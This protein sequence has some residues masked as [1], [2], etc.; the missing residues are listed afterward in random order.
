MRHTMHFE[1]ENDMSKHNVKEK[2]DLLKQPVQQKAVLVKLAFRVG[3][4]TLTLGRYQAGGG[5]EFS[6]HSRRSLRQLRRKR[7]ENKPTVHL[8]VRSL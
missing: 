1:A 2:V 6:S 7:R 5:A 8:S 4:E 3:L